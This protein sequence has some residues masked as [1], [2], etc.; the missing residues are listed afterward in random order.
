[1]GAAEADAPPFRQFGYG[2]L[3]IILFAGLIALLFQ[4]LSTRLG[5]VSD[6]GVCLLPLCRET[7][8]LP[9]AQRD[10]NSNPLTDLAT[11][12]RFA[13]YDRDSPYK[14]VYRYAVLYPLYVIAEIG[15]IMTDLAELLGSAIAINLCV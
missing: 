3:F 1:M 13:L 4:I 5:C 12:C 15:I 14:L 9:P 8:S 2:H 11:H 10:A 6:Y 7:F